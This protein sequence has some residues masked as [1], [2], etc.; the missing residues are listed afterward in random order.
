P[1]C[2]SGYLKV[3]STICN[4][5]RAPGVVNVLQGRPMQC[6]QPVRKQPA[7]PVEAERPP[8][9]RLV[10]KGKRDLESRLGGRHRGEIIH[11]LSKA[12]QRGNPFDEHP[13]AIEWCGQEV[14]RIREG[15][16]EPI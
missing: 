12:E 8:D 9:C 13:R 16:A 6:E 3:P 1:S 4:V 2:R 11:I 7:L 15:N 10:S 14:Q 5:T